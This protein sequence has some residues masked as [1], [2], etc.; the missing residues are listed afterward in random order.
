MSAA[1]IMVVDDD[2]DVRGL[3]RTTLDGDGF[4]I[5]EARDGQQALELAAKEPPDL[6]IL[7]WQMP[8][9]SGPEVLTQLKRHEAPPPVILLT[10]QLEPRYSTLAQ[11][12]G[13]DAYL[14]KP[15]SPLQLSDIVESLLA[16]RNGDGA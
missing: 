11:I 2:A 9:L 10:A 6:V 4:E 16:A 1:R 5:I 12:F 15:F 7:D 14:T 8:G 13:A 3:L